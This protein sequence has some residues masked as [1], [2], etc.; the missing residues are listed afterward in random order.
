MCRAAGL[1]CERLDQTEGSCSLWL[2]YERHERKL[3]RSSCCENESASKEDADNFLENHSASYCQ[4]LSKFVYA[5]WSYTARRSRLSVSDIVYKCKIFRGASKQ[6]KKTYA[7]KR[8][9]LRQ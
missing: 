9:H 3:A 2:K 4:K 8:G 5:T 1:M 7:R 6:S